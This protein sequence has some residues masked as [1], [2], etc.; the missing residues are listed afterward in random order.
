MTIC[1]WSWPVSPRAG[2]ERVRHRSH[3]EVGPGADELKAL[4]RVEAG[5]ELVTRVEQPLPQSLE[6]V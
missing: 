6:L 4:A 3:A 2:P 5:L 1:G